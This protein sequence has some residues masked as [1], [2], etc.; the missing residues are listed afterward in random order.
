MDVGEQ[1]TK[2]GRSLTSVVLIGL[3]GL[4][5]MV[6]LLWPRQPAVE[7]SA[8]SE[9]GSAWELRADKAVLSGPTMG[10]RFNVVIA[11]DSLRLDAL[12]P[13]QAQI[14]AELVAVNAEMS[15]YLA[16]SE[17]SRFNATDA[18]EPIHASAHLLEVVGLAKQV[19]HQS[20]GAFDVTVGPLVDAWGFGPDPGTRT[21][22]NDA[23]IATLRERVGDAK[24]ELDANAKTLRKTVDG[25]HVD[26]S[27]IAKGHGCDRVAARVDAAGYANYMIEVGGEVRVRGSNP[28]GDPW[29]V[30][31]ERPTADA[32]GSRAV[33]AILRIRDA[34]VATSGDYRNYWERDGVRYS[35]TIDP[36]TGRPIAHRLASV[37][38]VHPESAALADAWATA[39]NVL[40]PEQGLALAEQLG[41]AAYFLVRTDA[42]FEVRTSSAYAAYLP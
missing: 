6:Y 16:D 12:E 21:E 10:T 19:N 39:L 26:L 3:L 31:I 34:A 25:L 28:E 11:G 32:A 4:G 33:Q 2:S 18:S 1:Q 30:G 24:L 22:L 42:G 40:G 17:L 35:H 36:R 23:Q 29:R 7:R 20:G 5:G 14:D 41:L 9:A 8:I 27:A 38:V 13:L 37:T 15:T